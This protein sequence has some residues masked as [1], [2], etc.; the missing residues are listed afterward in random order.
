MTQEGNSAK[1]YILH[2]L[3]KIH[4]THL[5]ENTFYTPY[6]RSHRPEGLL[7]TD[8]HITCDV[9]QDSRLEEVTS[10]FMPLTTS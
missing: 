8:D 9:R 1:K 2:T 7:T 3:W 5:M 6:E 4:F 10:K